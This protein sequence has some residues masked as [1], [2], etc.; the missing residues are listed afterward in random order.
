MESYAVMRVYL[1]AGSELRRIESAKLHCFVKV[2]TT[3]C[4]KSCIRVRVSE[5]VMAFDCSNPERIN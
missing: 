4:I 2:K 5:S 1:T 3:S